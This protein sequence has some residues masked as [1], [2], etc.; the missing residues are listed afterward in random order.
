VPPAAGGAT[1]SSAASYAE[2]EAAALARGDKPVGISALTVIKPD[3]KPDEP[4]ASA[5]ELAEAALVVGFEDGAARQY[6]L[7]DVLFAA[8][9]GATRA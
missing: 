5:R 7:V 8:C 3:P 1:R 4:R 9:E 6:R 2:Y